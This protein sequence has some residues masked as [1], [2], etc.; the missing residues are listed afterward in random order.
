[1]K[2]VFKSKTLYLALLFLIN[3]SLFIVLCVSTFKNDKSSYIDFVP[4]TTNAFI[5]TTSSRYEVR[6]KNF[7]VFDSYEG[8]ISKDD[9]M[10][11]T[12]ILDSCDFSIG[13]TVEK[14]EKIGKFKD[15]IVYSSFESICIDILLDSENNS[16]VRFYNFNQ[17]S[18]EIALTFREYTSVN[19]GEMTGIYFSGNG[20]E[21]NVSFDGYDYDLL[22]EKSIINAR[23]RPTNCDSFITEKSEVYIKVKKREY[24]NQFYLPASIFDDSI[25]SKSFY[26][27]ENS[28]YKLIYIDSIYIIDN[29]ALIQCD[30]Y[31]LNESLYLYL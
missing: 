17:F 12:Y 5:P 27:I 7:E 24:L 13:S 18:I 10:Y 25:C 28:D 15:T 20:Y 8:I 22:E 29:Y 2:K 30:N 3:T 21:Y 16:V 6:K 11:S 1:M 4:D 23:F 19:F 14:N 26:I 9:E 31:I